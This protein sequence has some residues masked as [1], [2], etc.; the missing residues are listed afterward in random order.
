VSYL[1]WGHTQTVEAERRRQ[2]VLR[3]RLFRQDGR[4]ATRAFLALGRIEEHDLLDAAE[5]F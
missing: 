1:P 2:Q 5:F 3:E 4:R